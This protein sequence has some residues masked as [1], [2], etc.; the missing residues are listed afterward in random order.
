M[1]TEHQGIAGNWINV[2]AGIWLIIAPFALGYGN[3][4]GATNDI[5]LGII[6]GV[7]G[8]IRLFTTVRGMWLNWVNLIAGL[9]LIIAPF[10]MTYA[11]TA[12]VWNDIILGLVVL[13]CSIW[14]FGQT[15]S[16]SSRHH[17]A[18]I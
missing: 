3:S 8:F 15:P 14:A 4:D 5:W 9:W 7:I 17:H 12:T 16:H 6:V 13:G 18:G 1:E 10:T 2:L 11:A